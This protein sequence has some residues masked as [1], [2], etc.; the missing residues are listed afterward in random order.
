MFGSFKLLAGDYD[1][2][3]AMFTSN[4]F[5]FRPKGKI[6]GGKTY[7]V[8]NIESLEQLDEENK[9]K[10]LG[11]LGWGTAGLVA[12]GPLGAIGG[13][14]IGGKRKKVIFAVQFS[15]GKKIMGETDAKLFTRMRAATF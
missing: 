11:T 14:M 5:V 12:L 6:T 2:H 9:K 13:M 10:V 1:G 8:A 15:D 4:K 7:G 3:E